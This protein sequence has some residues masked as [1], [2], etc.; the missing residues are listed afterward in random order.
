[1]HKKESPD[2]KN[3]NNRNTPATGNSRVRFFM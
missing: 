2:N 1:M 3:G